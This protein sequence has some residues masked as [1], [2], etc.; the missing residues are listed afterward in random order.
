MRIIAGKFRG[1]RLQPSGAL[2]LRPTSDRLRE[3]LFDVIAAAGGLEGTRWLDL[4]A[5]TGAV[6][7][8]ALSRGASCACFVESARAPA[9]LIKRNLDSLDI[10]GC[11]TILQKPALKALDEL[12]AKI[13]GG[14]ERAFDFS[15]LDPPYRLEVEYE[16]VFARLAKSSVLSTNALL[17]AEHSKHFE[18]AALAG[19]WSRVRRLQQGDAVLSFYRQLTTPSLQQ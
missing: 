17:V 18:L 8:E 13:R 10:A 9:A 1:R 2:D 19:T 11:A 5:G 7:I 15:F 4:Y 12:D 14:S 16:R 3:T 6:G